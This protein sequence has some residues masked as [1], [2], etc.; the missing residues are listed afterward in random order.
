MASTE[1]EASAWVASLTGDGEAFA[2]IFDQ[3]SDRIYRHSQRLTYNPFDA[4][5]LVV[6][7]ETRTTR[8]V[9]YQPVPAIIDPL[10]WVSSIEPSFGASP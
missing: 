2:S 10:R 1:G 3:H 8:W 6:A 7:A 5:D 4:D 9:A